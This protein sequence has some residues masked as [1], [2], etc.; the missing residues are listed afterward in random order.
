MWKQFYLTNNKWK[1]PTVYCNVGVLYTAPAPLASTRSLKT[2][3]RRS[4]SFFIRACKSVTTKRILLINYAST[5][6]KNH[7]KFRPEF[8][9]YHIK[10]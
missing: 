4:Y 5:K 9:R 7:G 2:Q 8:G 1:Y 10:E 6:L 3:N